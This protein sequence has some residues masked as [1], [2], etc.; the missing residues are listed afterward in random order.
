MCCLLHP[1]NRLLQT[2][3][4]W[5]WDEECDKAFKEAKEK[6]V[7][8][9]ILAHY[10]LSK[11]LK[12]TADASA[13][14]ISAVLSHMFA[15]GRERQI[16]YASTIMSKAE[17]QYAQIDKEALGLMFGVQHFHQYL[18]GRKF[19]LVTEHKPLL[20]IFGPKYVIPP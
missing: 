5:K 6:L 18:Y 16:A 14:G 3:T 13:Y 17:Q 10:D 7:S 2:S 20:S 4:K 1:L 15:N 19:V 8:A 9:S 11:K 12:L